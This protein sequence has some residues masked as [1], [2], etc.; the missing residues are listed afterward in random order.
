MCWVSLLPLPGFSLGLNT[1]LWTP[2]KHKHT[3]I[4]TH[5]GLL[6]GLRCLQSIRRMRRS[7]VCLCVAQR[8]VF[9]W[10]MFLF[11]RLRGRH[12]F[13][14]E[15]GC[16]SSGCIYCTDVDNTLVSE[17]LF[18]SESACMCRVRQ[19]FPS[20]LS[21]GMVKQQTLWFLLNMSV[22]PTLMYFF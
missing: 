8:R 21:P 14:L 6:V 19:C 2:V 17:S 3:P 4:H 7:L 20:E 10:V 11:F 13:T 15:W 16:V 1:G 9:G 12:S 22:K 18:V 5:T